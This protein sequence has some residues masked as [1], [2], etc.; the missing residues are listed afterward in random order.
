MRKVEM[1]MIGKKGFIT[2]YALSVDNYIYNITKILLA[3]YLKV[4]HINKVTW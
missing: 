1:K 3:F 2:G 4:K